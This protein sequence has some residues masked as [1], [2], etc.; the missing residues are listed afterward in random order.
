MTLCGENSFLKEALR[1]NNE[2]KK[3]FKQIFAAVVLSSSLL[4]ANLPAFADGVQSAVVT[5]AA[6]HTYALSDNL[7]VEVEGVLN[8]KNSS[9]VRLGA[10]IRIINTSD[11]T[12][13][14]PDHELRIRTAN[15][16]VYTLKPSSTNVH[17]V[18]PQSKVELTYVKQIDRQTE[19]SLSDLSLVDVDYQ[20]YPKRETNLVTIPVSALAWN[21][22]LSELKD[23]SLLKNWTDSFTIPSLESPL[24]YTPDSITKTYTSSGTSFLVKLLVENPSD[25]T[26]TVP[27]IELDGKS[28]TDIYEG[29]PAE[30]GTVSLDGGEKKYIHFAIPADL[31]TTLD[32]INVLTNSTFVQSNAAGLATLTNFDIGKL[33]ISL[34]STGVSEPTQSTYTFGTPIVF[35]QWNDFMNPN[36]DVSLVELHVTDNTEDGSKTGLA[37]FKLVN[38]GEKPIPV[39]A[40]QTEL[41][42][43]GGYAYS[44]TRQTV[45]TQEIAPGTGT[46]VSYGFALPATEQ[47]EQFKLD[48]QGVIQDNAQA[49]TLAAAPVYKSTIASYNVSIQSDNDHNN[50]SLYPLTLNIKSWTVSQLMTASLSYTYRLNLDMDVVRDPGVVLD[51]SF[52]KLKF[53]LVDGLGRTLGFSSFPFTGTNRLVSGT[54]L[55][56]FSNLTQDQIQNNVSIKVYEAVTT[57]TGEV[58]RFITELK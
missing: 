22:N 40:F 17:G 31:D 13:R 10:V 33:N 30:T 3:P 46:V 20:V 28:K 48:V 14:I 52:S 50:I 57:P 47:S 6:V 18:Q 12:V 8:E 54:Q 24:T 38:K 26:E 16:I 1:R 25:Q 2:M 7:Q 4:V 39:P 53:E 43:K 56:S 23:P 5:S 29:K 58:D 19:V 34:P 37:K 32:S 21:G 36:L 45:S 11:S 9:G 27:A 35:E 55:L 49:Q 15:G 41:S 44:G 42:G 51:D